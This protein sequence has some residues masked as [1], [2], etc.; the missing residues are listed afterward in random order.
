MNKKPHSKL[1]EGEIL[2][3]LNDLSSY[4]RN[5]SKSGR[6]PSKTALCEVIAY[7]RD[8][9]EKDLHR[10]D[11]ALDAIMRIS[12]TSRLY[13]PDSD[14]AEAGVPTLEQMCYCPSYCES[15]IE[16]S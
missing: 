4:G 3:I 13:T 5:Y 15:S 12:A 1:V 11:M 7:L 14:L 2:Y 10:K 16:T 8:K 6:C 9:Q